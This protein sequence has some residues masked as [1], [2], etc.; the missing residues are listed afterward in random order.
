M[1]SL[2]TNINENIN[3]SNNNNNIL[4]N[5]TSNN[6]ILNDSLGIKLNTFRLDQ[7]RDKLDIKSNDIKEVTDNLPNKYR[8]SLTP[9]K[10]ILN[11]RNRMLFL[12]KQ[13]NQYKKKVIYSQFSIILL[14]ILLI[15]GIIYS[16]K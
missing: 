14:L 1:N 10:S 16:S 9:D 15:I 3:L 8:N 12:L 5:I 4:G 6:T 2:N 11:T 13:K 7:E